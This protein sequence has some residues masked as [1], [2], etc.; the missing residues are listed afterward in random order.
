MSR[1]LLTPKSSHLPVEVA[2][3]AATRKTVLQLATPSTTA[4]RILGWGVSFDGVAAGAE[5]GII[6]L[7]ETNVAATVTTQ[8]PEKQ[9]A[10]SPASLCVGGT[11]ASGYGGSAE[12]TITASRFLDGPQEVHPQTGY[13]VWFDRGAI[14]QV[15]QFVRIRC[16][17]AA[18]VNVIPWI[19]F[20]EP[21]Q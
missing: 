8:D 7:I 9:N 1:Y 19:A 16:L 3:A 2:L 18:A 13:S 5:P 10:Q 4:V 12:G 15:S 20:E 17:F 14:V 21:V 11:S 6:D